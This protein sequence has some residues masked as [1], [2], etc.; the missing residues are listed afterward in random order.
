MNHLE[1]KHLRMIRSIADTGNMT[2]A[3]QK[4][5]IT[6]SALSQQLKDIENKLN[7]SLFF[8]TH[9]KMILTS[10]GKKVLKTAERVIDALEDT[11]LEI[12]RMV[13]GARGSLKV[14]TQC[15]FCYKWL[16]KVMGMFQEKF[17]NVEVEIGNSM[18][19]QEDL[20]SKKYDL[21][22]TGAPDNDD[23]FTYLPLFEDHLVCILPIDHPLKARPHVQLED[24]KSVN[25]ISHSEKA[26]NKFYLAALKPLDIEPVKYMTVGHPQAIIE[27]VAAGFGVSIFPNWAIRSSLENGS[28][29]ARPITPRGLP[30][31]WHAA[32]FA[33]SNPPGFQKEFINI[34]SKMN[35]VN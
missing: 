6:Q 10:T 25:L 18:H 33:D 1:I 20:E 16:P 13:K 28:I 22:I 21:I 2:R 29:T 34:V 31:T 9:K 19:L 14:G 27:M 24:F 17:P 30:V 4:L 12:A 15:I 26:R 8:R 23:N 32:L 5:F 11:E 7:A 35:L 3:A